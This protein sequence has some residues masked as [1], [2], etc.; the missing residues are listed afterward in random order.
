M[1]S[2]IINPVTRRKVSIYGKIGKQV[3][4]NYI[5]NQTSNGG[6]KKYKIINGN[7]TYIANCEDFKKYNWISVPNDMVVDRKNCGNLQFWAKDGRQYFTNNKDTF[8]K[9][10]LRKVLVINK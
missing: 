6:G 5:L 8:R 9:G 10:V 1:W 4:R 3:L 2:T 7:A